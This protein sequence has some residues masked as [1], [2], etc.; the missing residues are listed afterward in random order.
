MDDRDHA[1][2]KM[3][4]RLI[5]I[6]GFKSDG[7]ELIGDPSDSNNLDCYKYQDRRPG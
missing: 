1:L 7:F 2:I 3:N 6:V 5:L 4:R